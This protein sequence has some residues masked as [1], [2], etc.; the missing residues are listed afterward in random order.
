MVQY[1][2]VSSGSMA[3][4]EGLGT[5]PLYY[6]RLNCLQVFGADTLVSKFTVHWE[7]AESYQPHLAPQEAYGKVTCEKGIDDS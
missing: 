7:E 4:K 2:K 1:P 5:Y 3:L 6:F